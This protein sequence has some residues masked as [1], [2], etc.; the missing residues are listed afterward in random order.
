MGPGRCGSM[1]E[2]SASQWPKGCKF[3]LQST[4]ST[5]VVIRVHAGA[6]SAEAMNWC[7]SSPLLFFSLLLPSLPPS[8]PLSERQ[9]E[10]CSHMR[11][12]NSNKKIQMIVRIWPTDWSLPTCF[13]PGSKKGIN[14]L[15]SLLWDIMKFFEGS[16]LCLISKV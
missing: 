4:P 10:K 5:C 9:W 12:N 13:K 15:K 6:T 7:F 11:I 3:D 14:P 16:Y 1:V 2:A 8:I